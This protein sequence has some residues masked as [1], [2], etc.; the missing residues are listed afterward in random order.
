MQEN[1]HPSVVTMRMR[2]GQDRRRY[3]LPSHDEVAAIFVGDN[4]GGPPAPRQRDIVIYPRDQPLTSIST[5][6]ANLDP[7]I[8]PLFL[9]QP[10]A[11]F[12][13]IALLL[14]L[15]S[16]Q[17]CMERSYFNSILLMPIHRWKDKDWTLYA[18]TSSLYV[19]NSTRDWLTMWSN[20]LLEKIL[21]FHL[22]S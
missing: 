7:M 1:R 5:L 20:V 14:G 17:Y 21:S 6:S 12:M 19:S 18:I 10:C 15:A 22:L 2:S 9:P 16:T 3:N 13:F 11:N 8:Y 4:E